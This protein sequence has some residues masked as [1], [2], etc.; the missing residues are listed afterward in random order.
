[1]SIHIEQMQE[2]LRLHPLPE[3]V[4]GGNASS[5]Q[6]SRPPSRQAVSIAR[7]SE[8]LDVPAYC[9]QYGVEIA[10]IEHGKSGETKYILAQCVFDSSHTGKDAAIFQ[11]A[12][13]KLGYKCFHNSCSSYSWKEARAKIS[14]DAPL[15]GGK[16][17]RSTKTAAPVTPKKKVSLADY[18]INN[19]TERLRKEMREA[20][21]IMEGVAI[22]GQYTAICAPPNGGK[23][24]LTIAGL[25]KAVREGVIA[26]SDVFYINVDDN[27]EG[28]LVK[29]EIVQELGINMIVPVLADPEK[30]G[31]TPFDFCKIMADDI[32]AKTVDGKIIVIDTYKKFTNIMDKESQSHF[33]DVVRRFVT[34]GGSV[35][36]LTH[37]N[38][39]R[40]QEGKLVWGG[41]SDL[42][43]DCDA[44][45]IIDHTEGPDGITYEFIFQKG[46][47][48]S[49]E[50]IAFFS[51]KFTHGSLEDDQRERYRRRL[52]G[53][54]PQSLREAEELR[55]KSSAEQRVRD[56]AAKY[57]PAVALIMGL[58]KDGAA[59]TRTEIE[60]AYKDS[61]VPHEVPRRKFQDVIST[62]SGYLWDVTPD[63]TRKVYRLKEPAA[64]PV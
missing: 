11:A 64:W 27:M 56:I 15:S 61:D 53:I 46:R 44:G 30:N 50:N 17:K 40:N 49:G 12:D 32:E 10:K 16:G 26:G 29:T 25:M 59:L 60:Q 48:H 41:T 14:G 31:N 6:S 57:H 62:L 19:E 5:K 9:Q 47:G 43:D 22:R 33:N 35:I 34:L 51:P 39:N 13:G 63:G 42:K 45:W 8:R 7:P 24:L 36:V 55:R 58:L 52:E 20:V 37:V 2:Y 21:F 4:P 38:K 3:Q 18:C 23:T 1:M 28:A 54:E